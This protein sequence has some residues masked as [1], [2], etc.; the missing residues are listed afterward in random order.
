MSRYSGER[1]CNLSHDSPNKFQRCKFKRCTPNHANFEFD[2]YLK[3]FFTI[4][5]K[6]IRGYTE[7]TE[8][9]DN[10]TIGLRKTYNFF[11]VRRL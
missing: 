3:D 4:A 9:R 11:T 5:P 2:E 1:I 8:Q 10:G 6:F 7:L